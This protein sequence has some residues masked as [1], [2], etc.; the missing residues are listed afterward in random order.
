MPYKSPQN[1]E[2]SQ[3]RVGR[4]IY[5]NRT[6]HGYTSTMSH[7]VK[8]HL[9]PDEV[10]NLVIGGT[11]RTVTGRLTVPEDS[12]ITP[13][14]NFALVDAQLKSEK[15]DDPPESEIRY[16]ACAVENDGTFRLECVPPGEW[17]M[18]AQL[19]DKG[20]ERSWPESVGFY[21]RLLTIPENAAEETMDL[22]SLIIEL[23]ERKE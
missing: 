2:C 18:N 23:H 3:A 9:E 21:S 1:D 14:W 12:D 6:D 4:N 19:S 20:P 17:K 22:G 15:T 13:D 7:S 16:V 8:L 5:F 11:G 10:K